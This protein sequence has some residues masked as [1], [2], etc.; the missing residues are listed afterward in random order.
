M[1]SKAANGFWKSKEN[2]DK[3]VLEFRKLFQNVM[4][5]FKTAKNQY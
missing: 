4:K 2:I 1:K 5:N 3:K